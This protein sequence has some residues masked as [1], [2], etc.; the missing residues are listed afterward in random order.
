[1]PYRW[2]SAPRSPDWLPL[3]GAFAYPGRTLMLGITAQGVPIPDPEPEP[4][5]DTAWP[6]LEPEPGA[7]EPVDDEG[8]GGKHEAPDGGEPHA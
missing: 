2:V 7:A 4:V 6:E 1:M 3:V 8:D 5:D